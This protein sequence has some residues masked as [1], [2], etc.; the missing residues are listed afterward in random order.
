MRLAANLFVPAALLLLTSYASTASAN[1]LVDY[2][3]NFSELA[4]EVEFELQQMREFNGELIREFNRELLLEFGSMIPRMRQASQELEMYIQNRDDVEDE[5]REY[6]VFLFELYRTFQEFDIQDC[7]YYAFNDL[8]NDAL[9]RFIPMERS[10]SKENYRSISQTVITLGR[11]NVLEPEEV[12]AELQEELEY[13]TVLRDSYRTLLEEE[14]AKHGD[15]AYITINR[16]EDCRDEAFY[17]QDNDIEYIKSYLDEN[18][19]L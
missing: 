15:D 1:F 11:N 19:Y 4:R 12:Q 13:F 2:H 17:W 9:Y 18:C 7:A 10:Y 8:R 5:C 3:G 14:L 6:T 16:F